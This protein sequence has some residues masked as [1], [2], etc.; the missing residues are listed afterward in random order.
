LSQHFFVKL[1]PRRPT[2]PQDM[3]EDERAI[4]LQH[5]DYW[6]DLMRKKIVIVFG[7]VMDPVGVFGMGVIETEDETTV[8]SL[9]DNDPAIVL[10]RYELY[11]MRAVH[12][13]QYEKLGMEQT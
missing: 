1:I 2:F 9:L 6:T 13:G 11:P 4:M 10:N 5:R 8:K 12:P 3:T 7:P